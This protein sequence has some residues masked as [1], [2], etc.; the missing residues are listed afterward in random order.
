V[1][2]DYLRKGNLFG[3]NYT[4]YCWSDLKITRLDSAA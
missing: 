2:M 1:R 3:L 4:P